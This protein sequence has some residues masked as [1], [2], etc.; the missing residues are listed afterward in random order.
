M[1]NARFVEHIPFLDKTGAAIEVGGVKLGMNVD[2]VVAK[3][4]VLLSNG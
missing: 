1:G 4:R 2:N 3:A